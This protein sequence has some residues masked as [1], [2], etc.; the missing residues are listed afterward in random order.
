[1]QGLTKYKSTSRGNN[2]IIFSLEDVPFTLREL[3][4]SLYKDFI[5]RFNFIGDFEKT[6]DRCVHIIHKNPL[7]CDDSSLFDYCAWRQDEKFL[8]AKDGV[9][10]EKLVV[11]G[12]V[13]KMV[14]TYHDVYVC[15][16]IYAD[17]ALNVIGTELFF[18]AFPFLRGTSVFNIS[19]PR[20]PSV[21][22]KLTKDTPVSQI[23]NVLNYP[24]DCDKKLSIGD[25]VDIITNPDKVD[26]MIPKSLF[27]IYANGH[28]F[29]A[30]NPSEKDVSKRFSL[31]LNAEDFIT[32]DW[33]KV[34]ER[35]IGAY[36][37]DK[38]GKFVD[39]YNRDIVNDMNCEQI[40]ILYDT[41]FDELAK[42]M[43]R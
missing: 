43:A 5:E 29:M 42:E 23:E 35:R 10:T 30:I 18:M 36:K 8:V 41:I 40:K 19:E 24:I 6:L 1:M 12:G 4:G 11:E 31:F 3:F 9:Y 28:I 37:D 13:G 16:P 15:K 38:I 22:K 25:I 20:Y 7:Y 32:R 34:L 26:D 27:T 2:F 14:K 21:V 33:G 17:L 39:K